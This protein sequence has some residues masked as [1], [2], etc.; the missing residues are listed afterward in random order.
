MSYGRVANTISVLDGAKYHGS[1]LMARLALRIPKG[2]WRVEPKYQ[3]TLIINVRSMHPY[4]H[5]KHF[6]TCQ[7][8]KSRAT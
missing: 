5:S 1:I 4:Y 6:F 2:V 3:Y 7:V 8:N